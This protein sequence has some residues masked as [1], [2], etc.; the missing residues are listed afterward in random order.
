MS[1]LARNLALF[2]IACG[3]TGS[4]IW[5]N[6]PLEPSQPPTEVRLPAPPPAPWTKL[7]TMDLIHRLESATTDPARLDAAARMGGI[8]EPHL[9]KALEM[10]TLVSDHKLTLTARALLIHWAA[11]D[12]DAACRWAWIR[13]RSQGLWKY[14]FR[15]IGPSWAA[16]H[17]QA[18]EKCAIA[19]CPKSR[20][21]FT[22]TL[23][24][25]EASDEPI[26]D[27]DMLDNV[28][29]WLIHEDPQAAYKVLQVRGGLTTHDNL[30]ES[31]QTVDKI[32]QALLAFDHLDEM[33]PNRF[34]GS[35]IFAQSLLIQWHK[36]DPEDFSRSPYAK[37]A[38]SQGTSEIV[39]PDLDSA[40]S[41][42]DSVPP[43]QRQAGLVRAFDAWT[44]AH[45]GG[46]PDM[47]GWTEVRRRAW[48]DLEALKP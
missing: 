28:S 11:K 41:Q 16:H 42:A 32:R 7:K 34:K 20:G 19:H 37:F 17:P 9:A 14:A 33:V 30:A 46:R 35:E 31:L 2:G 25:A 29:R 48:A 47:S 44:K 23:Q 36:L 40:L 24:T 18:L 13:F 5:L 1:P 38:P 6:R 12:G 27:F 10:V 21:S 15:E 4:V 22:L 8:P 39:P 43:E 3:I 45:P 26:L